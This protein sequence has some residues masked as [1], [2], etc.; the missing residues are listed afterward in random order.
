[1]Y[2]EYNA[3]FARYKWNIP[4]R[5]IALKDPLEAFDGDRYWAFGW[6]V[7]NLNGWLKNFARERPGRPYATETEGILALVVIAKH[8]ELH[9]FLTPYEPHEIRLK[10]PDG[11]EH[12]CKR[13]I[14]IAV[15]RS[16]YRYLRRPS[17]DG[18]ARLD[19][20]LPCKPRWYPDYYERKDW[21]RH[22]ISVNPV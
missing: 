1:M 21:G 3:Q 4:K 19:A 15:T 8:R 9:D 2:D 17:A 13:M 14:A 22:M 10:Y 16:V 11:R 6:V 20:V 18:Y 7:E 12:W 5:Y